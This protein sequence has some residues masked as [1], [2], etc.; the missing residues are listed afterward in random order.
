MRF[1]VANSTVLSTDYR[2][3]CRQPR[4]GASNRSFRPIAILT[5]IDALDALERSATNDVTIDRSAQ[6]CAEFELRSRNDFRPTSTSLRLSVLVRRIRAR[7]AATKRVEAWPFVRIERSGRLPAAVG[8][9]ARPRKRHCQRN[10]RTKFSAWVRPP[11][12]NSMLLRAS[13]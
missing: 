9:R 10:V 1:S 3:T 5:L 12:R 6:L 4:G 8:Q 2:H 7:R 13:G 11:R